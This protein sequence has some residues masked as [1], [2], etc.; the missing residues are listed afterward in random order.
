MSA[1]HSVDDPALIELRAGNRRASIAPHIGGAITAFFDLAGDGERLHWLRPASPEALA[2]RNPLGM[3]SFPLLPYCNRLRDARFVF[4][5]EA[6]DLSQ[7]GNA[8]DHA[9]HGH[10]WRRP[11]D[12]LAVSANACELSLT[13]EPS[14]EAAHHWPY[15]YKATQRIELTDVGN[16]QVTLAIH[17]LSDKPMPFGMGHHPYYPRTPSTRIHTRVRAMWHAT[18]DLLPTMLG[19]HESVEMLASKDGMPADAFDLDNNFAGWSRSATIEWPDENRSV[20]LT[21]EPPFNHMVLYAPAAHPDLLCVEPVSNTVDFLNLD[22][23][24]EDK[25]GGVLQPG[26]GVQARFG[27]RPHSGT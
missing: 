11:W 7:D 18:P 23:P 21:A 8:F 16:L 22:V 5:G 1:G 9:L 3:A 27:W 2:A 4:N 26:E 13:H 24:Q 12:V 14:G 19:A 20:T 6:V 10:A 15:R 25:G 17:N